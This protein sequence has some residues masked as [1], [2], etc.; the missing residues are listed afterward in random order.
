MSIQLIS[1]FSHVCTTGKKI[2]P[3]A[4]G[5]V[6]V[7]SKFS[8][9]AASSEPPEKV[10]TPSAPDVSQPA[11]ATATALLTLPGI[12]NARLMVGDPSQPWLGE[13]ETV[14]LL[15]ASTAAGSVSTWAYDTPTNKKLAAT[16]D[17][18]TADIRMARRLLFICRKSTG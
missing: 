8:T 4:A 11:F 7:I 18:A 9:V 5:A 2:G 13:N 16:H 14:A 10:T 1:P 6:K 3:A 12:L 15:P 17:A